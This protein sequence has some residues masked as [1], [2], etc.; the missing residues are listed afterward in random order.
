M[1]ATTEKAPYNSWLL[2]F[3]KQSKHIH[4]YVFISI[5]IPEVFDGISYFHNALQPKT[6]EYKS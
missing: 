5:F 6:S 4:V 1:D 2:T 3:S